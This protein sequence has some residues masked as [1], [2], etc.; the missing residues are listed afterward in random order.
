MNNM[1]RKLVQQ[2]GQ[3]YT[4]TLPISWVRANEL[5]AGDDLQ[6]TVTEN[7]ITIQGN[8]E[9]KTGKAFLDVSHSDK[10]M[11]F[12]ALNA[13][14]TRGVDELVMKTAQE[15]SVKQVMGYAI[16]E[17]KDNLVTIKDISGNVTTNLEDIFKRV[18]QMIIAFCKEAILD[19]TEKREK[20][21]SHINARDGDINIFCSYLLRAIMKN[22]HAD[23][24]Q[25]KILFTYAYTLE[26][27]GDEIHRIWRT[28]QQQKV[29]KIIHTAGDICIASLENAFAV[30][31][32]GT[33]K[34]QAKQFMYKNEIRK[35]ETKDANT[36]ILL[37][38]MVK[39]V[40]MIC[41]LTQLAMMRQMKVE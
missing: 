3:A 5:T 6:L 14:Y 28:P 7:K 11:H 2:G 4:I 29:P 40:E 15:F 22:A 17:N 1:N 30:C 13:A 32:R 35:L 10:R 12:V 24:A 37:M 20:K 26:Q 18:F 25:G 38:R 33:E 8:T 41:D 27:I 19:I 21:L 31:F 34:L 36:M 39:M 9:S 16:L 23:P